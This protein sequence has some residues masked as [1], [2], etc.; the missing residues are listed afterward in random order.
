MAIGITAKTAPTGKKVGDVIPL[1]DLFTFTDSAAGDYNYVMA[2]AGGG[3]VSGTNLTLLKDGSV[4]VTATNKTTA[5]VTAN[6]TMSVAKKDIVA[7][8]STSFNVGGDISIAVLAKGD[9][10]GKWKL[11]LSPTGDDDGWVGMIDYTDKTGSGFA[12]LPYLM[13]Y[14]RLT[15]TAGTKGSVEFHAYGPG[16]ESLKYQ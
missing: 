14:Y 7:I 3:K 13:P 6:V 2:P 4:K 16:V 8:L 12:V 15:A 11:E 5:S 1:G 10:D 9:W